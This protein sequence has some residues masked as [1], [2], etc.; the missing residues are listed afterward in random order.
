MRGLHYLLPLKATLF[1]K[2]PRKPETG[3]MGR[4]AALPRV[5]YGLR[6]GYREHHTHHTGEPDSEWTSPDV[7]DGYQTL[8]EWFQGTNPEAFDFLEGEVHAALDPERIALIRMSRQEGRELVTVTPPKALR[9]RVD[10]VYAFP[11]LHLAAVL[12]P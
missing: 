7:P 3:H 2:H 1:H 12:P 5:H 11:I 6:A 10:V 8:Y 9:G 4:L